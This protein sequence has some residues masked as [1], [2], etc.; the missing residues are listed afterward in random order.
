LQT[1]HD[2]MNSIEMIVNPILAK[3]VGISKWKVDFITELFK[4]IFSRQGKVNF[5]NLS[6][7]SK[8]NELT[9]RRHFSICF[10]WLNFNL[11][12]VDLLNGIHIGV[13]DCSFINKSGKKTFG[14]DTFWS[15]VSS[16]AK[17][18]L[19]I[20]VLGVIEV[21]TGRTTVLDVSQTP[22]GIGQPKKVKSKKKKPVKKKKKVVKKKDKKVK[23]PP[24][25]SRID[26]YMEQLLDC[27]PQLAN[28]SYF[29]AD[30]FYAKSKVFETLISKQK[31]LITKLRTDANLQYLNTKPRVA[32][33]RGKLAKCDG[34]VDYK[35]FSKWE[36]VGSDEKYNHLTIYAQQ[37]YSPNLARMLK[38]VVLLDTKTNKYVVLASSDINLDA[39]LLVKYY[40]MRF[41]I[42]YI[43]RDAK[44]FMGLNNCQARDENKLDFHLNAS[45]SAVNLARII[46]NQN[47]E[48]NNSMTNFMRRNYN[49]KFVEIIKTKLSK[50]ADLD[51]NNPIWNQFIKWGNLV[52]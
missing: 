37:L 43:F 13:I 8:Y 50:I 36:L 29:V 30:G 27:L 1:T 49:Q 21:A 18:G 32:G 3:I 24:K 45:M 47:P 40:Q 33:Q 20:S 14:L 35:D 39:R 15:G 7:Y 10:D 28:I 46:I 9:H 38:I 42:E 41:N 17:L 51:L 44:Q 25:Y 19:E 31:Q 11:G 6:R 2:L 26:Y 16:T 23:I 22:A 48:Y 5:E 52:A 4:V 12:F 34:K